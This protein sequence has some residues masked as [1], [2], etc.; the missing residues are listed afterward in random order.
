MNLPERGKMTEVGPSSS[1]QRGISGCYVV[2]VRGV[3]TSAQPTGSVSRT[4]L[5]LT[6]CAQLSSLLLAFP[7]VYHSYITSV[8]LLFLPALFS[9]AFL[10]LENGYPASDL[11]FHQIPILFF[12]FKD[13][14]RWI[15]VGKTE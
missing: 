15:S 11:I 1:F 9:L 2:C 5:Q 13:L 10:S 12:A 14:T 3:V 8:K 4:C 7:L 6:G